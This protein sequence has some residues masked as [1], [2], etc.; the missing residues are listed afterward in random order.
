MTSSRYKKRLITHLSHSTYEPAE[1]RT[2]AADLGVPMDEFPAFVEAIKELAAAGQV[3]W[4]DDQLVNLPP[5][6]KSMVGSFR[7]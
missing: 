7:K 4:G 6:G 3:V 1:A 2:L 5:I